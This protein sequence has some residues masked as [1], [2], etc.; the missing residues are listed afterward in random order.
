[1]R[2]IKIVAM[3][4]LGI[5]FEHC[6]GV[7]KDGAIAVD[8]YTRGAETGDDIAYA[9]S[10]SVIVMTK[11]WSGMRPRRSSGSRAAPRL[12][13]LLPLSILVSSLAKSRRCS[14]WGHCCRM[15]YAWS[16]LE[17]SILF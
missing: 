9:F 17:T 15:A 12:E 14:G 5:Y 7:A 6:E 1:V 3:L 8:W 4:Y 10:G 13:M 16:R 2:E 11:T